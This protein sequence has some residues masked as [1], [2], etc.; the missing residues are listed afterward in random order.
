M[1][2]TLITAI[3][4]FAVRNISMVDQA[5]GYGRQSGQTIALAELGTTAALAQIGPKKEYYVN[6]A[7]TG[8]TCDANVGLTDR[9][10]YPLSQQE[11]EQTTT[12]SQ[13]ETLLE[14][15]VSGSETGSFGP[16]ANLTGLVDVELTDVHKASKYVEGQPLDQTPYDVTLT[17]TARVIPTPATAAPCGAGISNSTVKKR[18]R[19]HAIF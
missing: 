19:A 18:M 10:C 12:G 7:Q 15:S 2:T 8:F 16:L 13:G 3:G 1:I 5:V 14:P 9:S 6:H 4:V 11:I 17:T